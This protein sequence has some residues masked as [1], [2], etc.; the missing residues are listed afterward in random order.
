M[1]LLV[2]TSFLHYTPKT[3]P[4]KALIYFI[5]MVC[6][7]HASAQDSA[8]IRSLDRLN[9]TVKKDTPKTITIGGEQVSVGTPVTLEAP[10]EAS[11]W[12]VVVIFCKELWDT[13]PWLV[14]LAG[15]FVILGIAK[16][17]KRK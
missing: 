5:F 6:I 2:K 7:L 10:K 4:L 14:I 8:A 1:D 12:D 9:V 16:L 3:Q 17:A 11:T 15:L 13:K